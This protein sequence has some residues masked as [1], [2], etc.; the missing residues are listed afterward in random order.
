M[1]TKNS[2]FPQAKLPV[3][4]GT[5]DKQRGMLAL[6][7]RPFWMF[8]GNFILLI[9]AV[10][11]LAGDNKTS[12]VSDLVFWAGVT[13]L[14]IVRFLDVKFLDGQTATGQP[15]SIKHWRRYAILLAVISMVIWSGAH[16]AAYLF[17]S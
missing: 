2:R 5:I 7:A 6:I 3:E 8:F 15:A 17:K 9:S 1:S 10:N 16:L 11:I 4:T 14:I 12:Y 13:A